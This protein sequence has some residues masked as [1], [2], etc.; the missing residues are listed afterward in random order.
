VY[1]LTATVEQR[2]TIAT[3]QLTTA[4]TH[5]N[6]LTGALETHDEE[7]C[8]LQAWAGNTNMLH[9]FELNNG[10]VDAQTPLQQGGN[11]LAKWIKVLRSGEVVTGVG[12]DPDEPEYVVPLHLATDYSPGDVNTMPY[13]CKE[14]L[15]SNRAPFFALAMM[16]HTLDLTASAEVKCYHRH[17]ERQAQLKADRRA[18]IVEIEREDE[19]LTSIR[20]HL[21]GWRLHEWV[22][23][24][25]YHRDLIR[26]H[27]P[28]HTLHRYYPQQVHPGAG[29]GGPARGR[30]DV[31]T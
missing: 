9:N 24:L 15:Q 8:H 14:L 26:E 22:G 10:H 7:I 23:H 1:R 4:H 13:W 31:T 28:F 16:V 17:H 19:E 27:T 30:G 2:T 11:M 12:E 6:H 29:P 21:E 25:Q 20:H 3:Q 5:I 18:I